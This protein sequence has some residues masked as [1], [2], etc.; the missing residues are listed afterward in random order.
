MLKKNVKYQFLNGVEFLPIR[1]GLDNAMK[2]LQKKGLGHNPRKAEVISY[3]MEEEL[4]NRE[5]LCLTGPPIKIF[6]S[7]V[8][9][10]G[11]NLGLRT[12]EHRELRRGMFEVG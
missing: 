12:G 4:W 11:L 6:R 9:I 8:F 2:K 7:L 1:N 3:L 10:L 5:I